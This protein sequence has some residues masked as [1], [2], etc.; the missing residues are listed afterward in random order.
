MT[1][2]CKRNATLLINHLGHFIGDK[3]IR[4]PIVFQVVS[5]VE[6]DPIG[7]IIRRIS[8]A[9][10]LDDRSLVNSHLKKEVKG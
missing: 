10:L 4:F 6:R 7:Q 5:S 8:D 9:T 3:G 1:H 2:L